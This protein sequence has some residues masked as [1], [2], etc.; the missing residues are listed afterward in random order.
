MVQFTIGD[1]VSSSNGVTTR[2]AAALFTGAGPGQQLALSAATPSRM[3][4]LRHSRTAALAYAEGLAMCGL[5]QPDSVG[6]DQHAAAI[7]FPL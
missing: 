2:N 1:P 6:E 4:S 5:V 7:R 3:K